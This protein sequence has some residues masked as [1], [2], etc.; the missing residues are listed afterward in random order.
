[1]AA[2]NPA[3]ELALAQAELQEIEARIAAKQ[4]EAQAATD[5]NA[6]ASLRLEVQAAERQ[7]A[8]ATRKIKAAQVKAR[9]LEMTSSGSTAT[10]NSDWKEHVDPQ[11]GS[12]YYYN[13]KTG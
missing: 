12:K 7:K 2:S 13:E 11:S 10:A 8:A 4:A 9:K 3:N 1:M 5:K 6:R